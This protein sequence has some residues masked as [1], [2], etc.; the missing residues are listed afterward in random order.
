MTLTVMLRKLAST[1]V[2]FGPM[3]TAR[4]GTMK[5]EK[6]KPERAWMQ[7]AMAASRMIASATGHSTERL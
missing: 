6:P 3:M 2:S 4:N 1:T 7:A 5:R